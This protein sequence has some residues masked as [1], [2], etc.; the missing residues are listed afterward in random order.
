[1]RSGGGM[2]PERFDLLT[3][4]DVRDLAEATRLAVEGPVPPFTVL[5]VAADD[6]TVAE[7]L[8]VVFPRLYP[9]LGE[10]AGGLAGSQASISNARIKDV[11][12]WTP[13]YSWRSGER[14]G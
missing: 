10:M 5:F 13:R 7:P 8:S 6:S 2:R 12:G 1:M 4:V 3:Y 11:L 14:A 9:A